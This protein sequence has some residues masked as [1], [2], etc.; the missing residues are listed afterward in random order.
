M[1][2]PSWINKIYEENKETKITLINVLLDETVLAALSALIVGVG[3]SRTGC[4]FSFPPLQ[5]AREFKHK[6]AE[7]LEAMWQIRGAHQPGHRGDPAQAAHSFVTLPF[8]STKESDAAISKSPAYLQELQ[9][10][11]PVCLLRAAGAGLFS[12]KKP[13]GQG[14]NW[15]TSLVIP[16]QGGSQTGLA[17]FPQPDE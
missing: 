16:G 17:W 15:S 8:P 13:S 7:S 11:L 3:V 10:Q 2:G 6:Q 4:A 12:W 9:T 5:R 1:D 14:E